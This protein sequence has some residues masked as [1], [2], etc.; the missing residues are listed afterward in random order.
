MFFK[1]EDVKGLRGFGGVSYPY[2]LFILI[3]PKLGKFGG[4]RRRKGV[5]L[6]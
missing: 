4:S 2:K 3:S 6:V 5:S 1:E